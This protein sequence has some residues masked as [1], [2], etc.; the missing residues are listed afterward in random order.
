MGARSGTGGQR[1]L[2]GPGPAQA[3]SMTSGSRA[4]SNPFNTSGFSQ[5]GGTLGGTSILTLE[6][7]SHIWSGG[8][9]AGGGTVALGSGAELGM[10]WAFGAGSDPLLAG[11]TLRVDRGGTFPLVEFA[12]VTAGHNPIQIP[13]LHHIGSRRRKKRG[14]NLWCSACVQQNTSYEQSH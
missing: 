6:A 8:T 13:A 7:G 2:R 5:S 10:G 1:A 9:W 12:E 14:K 4:I 3:I 11:R